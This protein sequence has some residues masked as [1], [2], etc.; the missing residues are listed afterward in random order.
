[1]IRQPT[2]SEKLAKGLKDLLK[3]ARERITEISVGDA[4]TLL[5][6]PSDG[7]VLDVREEAELKAGRIP[8]ALHVP[9]GM[10]EPMAA[11]DSPL[12]KD[13]L[14]NQDQLIF[15]YCASGVRSALAADALQVLGFSN[16]RSIAGGFSAWVEAD[17]PIEN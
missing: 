16:V 15:V 12:R 3:E 10:L 4:R 9:R 8:G 6:K 1:L 11:E 13:A 17:H 7:L 5:E 2:G 14:A